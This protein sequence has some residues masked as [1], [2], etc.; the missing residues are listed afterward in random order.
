MTDSPL[1]A[2]APDAAVPVPADAPQTQAET[3]AGV[4]RASGLLALGN[5]TSRVLGLAREI[6]LSNLFGASGAVDAFNIALIIPKTLH[7]LLIAGHVNSAIVPVLSEVAAKEGKG[8]L[9]QLVSV[10]LSLIT[11][12]MAALILLLQLFAPQAVA[13]VG[14]GASAQTQ[15]LAVDLLRL[16]APALLFL[17]LFA[18]ASGTLYALRAFSLPAFAGAVFNGAVVLCMI[19]LAP[20]LGITAAAIGWLLGAVVQFAL[21]LPGFRL[22][23]LRPTLRW[24]RHPGVSRIALLYAPVMI[25]L[26]LDTLVRTVSYNF[27]SGTGEGSIGYMNWAT[28]LIQFPHGLVATAVSIAILPT[29]ARQAA[30]VATDGTQAFKDT[31][32]LGLRLVFV[33]IMPAT[34]GLFVM[35]TPITALLFE[36]GRFTATDTAI[37][38]HA[39]RLYLFG[40]P[41][42]ALDL[43]LV[44]AFYAQQ[45]T[46]TPALIGFG[47]LLVYLV[48]TV[49]LLPTLGLFSLMIADSVKHIVHTLVSAWLLH[50]RLRGMGGQR[51]L[52]TAVQTSVAVLAMGLLLAGV[53]PALEQWSDNASLLREIIVVVGGGALSVAVFVGVAW[54]LRIEELRWLFGLLRR[55][56]GR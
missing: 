47:S 19:V 44:Y 35:A 55:R 39:L 27:A 14:G 2:T 42:A 15:A 36:H 13:L 37:T 32:G 46:R 56:L 51:L 48:V 30:L 6:A 25:S 53:E 31:L 24:R 21:Q 23:S 3:N 10:L 22:S 38:A 26:I 28:T 49:A 1:E 34:I 41:F 7:D 54:L 18:V 11:T 17:A 43:L 45:D 50:R 4:A 12:I 29:L 16:T 52:L 20:T 9:W 8:A 5:I 33:L 40:L